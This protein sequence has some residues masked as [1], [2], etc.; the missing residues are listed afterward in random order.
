MGPRIRSVHAVVRRFKLCT[1][2]GTMLFFVCHPLVIV[3][4][5]EVVER[6]EGVLGCHFVCMQVRRW[7][8]VFNPKKKPA[9][10]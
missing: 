10:K 7:K 4:K 5:E 9:E 6:L 8:E 1:S 3:V 2:A